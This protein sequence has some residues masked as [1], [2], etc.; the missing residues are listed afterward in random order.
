MNDEIAELE[1]GVQARVGTGP[2]QGLAAVIED[3]SARAAAAVAVC[4]DRATRWPR[5]E[6]A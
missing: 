3:D 1:T 6:L 4:E 2:A 5:W